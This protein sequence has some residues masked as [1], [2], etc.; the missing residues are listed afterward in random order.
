MSSSKTVKQYSSIREIVYKSGYKLPNG[1][2]VQKSIIP[3][4]SIPFNRW[5]EEL[6]VSSSYVAP[7]PTNRAMEQIREWG[8]KS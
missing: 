6:G 5:A 7:P 4:H 3:V 1:A 2:V 8:V